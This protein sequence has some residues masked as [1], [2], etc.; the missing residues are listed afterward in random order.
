V[1]DAGH[2]VE[3]ADRAPS[4]VRKSL[5]GTQ[6]F[7]LGCVFLSCTEKQHIWQWIKW[8]GHVARVVVKRAVL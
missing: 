5:P 7:E 2:S 1:D 3:T 4:H 8:V 6:P